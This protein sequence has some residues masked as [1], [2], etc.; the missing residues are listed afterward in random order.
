MVANPN[1]PIDTNLVHGN[2]NRRE[3][4]H[5]LLACLDIHETGNSGSNGANEPVIH[6]YTI[7]VD[8]YGIVMEPEID[9]RNGKQYKGTNIFDWGMCN[10]NPFYR[11]DTLGETF[12]RVYGV[13]RQGALV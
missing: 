2:S 1:V 11:G 12:R 6:P 7:A 5:A 4:P 13:L 10:Y 8:K 3:S 9:F